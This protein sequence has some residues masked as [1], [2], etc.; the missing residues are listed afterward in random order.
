MNIKKTL[1]LVLIFSILMTSFVS[2][3]FAEEA[4]DIP[5]EDAAY[6]PAV[7][8]LSALGIME[9]K[10]DTE[11]GAE[12]LL[13][14]AEMSAVVTR[15]LGLEAG[16]TP[17]E[18]LVFDD[19]DASHWGKYYIDTAAALGIVNGSGDGI[20]DPDG[21]VTAEQAVK[22]LV[23][24]LGYEPKAVQSGGYP[25]GFVTTATQLG[26][27]KGIDFSDGMD[28]PI[29]RYK[30]AMLVYN[31]LEADL[32]EIK[33]YGDNQYSA[34]SKDT[35][36]LGAYHDTEKRTGTLTATYES[37]MVGKDLEPGEVIIDGEKY[38]TELNLGKYVGYEVDFYCREVKGRNKYEIIA[39]F[40][41][42]D[43]AALTIDFEDVETVT[44]SENLGVTVNYFKENGKS[45]KFNASKPVI[46]YNGKAVELADPA[47]AQ[48]FLDTHMVQGKLTYLDSSETGSGEII[49]LDNYDAYVVSRVDAE[50][51]KIF[52]NVYEVGR[53]NTLTL[54][55]ST[56]DN[57]DRKAFIY[58]ENGEEITLADLAANDVIMVYAS[59]D[60]ELYKVYQSKNQVTGVI[61]GISLKKSDS[62][63]ESEEGGE[64]EEQPYWETISTVTFDDFIMDANVK[65]GN[66]KRTVWSGKKTVTD[67][68]PGGKTRDRIIYL[69][70][71]TYYYYEQGR[72]PEV[73]VTHSP[74]AWGKWTGITYPPVVAN[75]EDTP[76][77]KGEKVFE[78]DRQY[79]FT[80]GNK[81]A[82]PDSTVTLYNIFNE[83]DV[84]LGD[85]V[86]ITAWVYAPSDKL[87]ETVGSPPRQNDDYTVSI[88]LSENEYTDRGLVNYV[89]ENG[90]R[91]HNQFEQATDDEVT[92][93][94]VPADQWNKVVMEYDINASNKNV[95]SIKI[96]NDNKTHTVGTYPYKF[97]VSGI[98]VEKYIDP[99]ADAGR[100]VLTADPTEY[101]IQI[102]GNEYTAASGFATSLLELGNSVTLLLDSNNKIV[103]YIRGLDKSGYGLLMDVG[104]KDETFGGGR[105]M[106]KILDADN[107]INIYETLAEVKAFNG[108]DV[109]KM[110]AADLVTNEPAD[111]LTDWH[112]WSTDN[113][114]NFEAVPRTWTP[115]SA[116]SKAASRKLVY[117]ETNSKGEVRTILVPSMPEDHPEARIIMVKDFE[118][119]PT[120]S[121]TST[122][123]HSYWPGFLTHQYTAGRAEPVYIM[124]NDAM[125]YWVWA[126]DY[127]E[128]DYHYHNGGLWEDNIINGMKW[129]QA[130]LYRLPGS[131]KIDFIV[132][133]PVRVDAYP[134]HAN[135]MIVDRISETEEG[136][137]FHGHATRNRGASNHDY[138]MKI[139][140]NLRLL[141]NLWMTA[142]D[143]GG[144]QL[145]WDNI[146][147]YTGTT[148]YSVS[149]EALGRKTPYVTPESVK[150]GDVVRVIALNNEIIY[151]EMIRRA[152]TGLVAPYS[153]VNKGNPEGVFS[154]DN[155]YTNGEIVE[156]NKAL[157]TVKIRGYYWGCS[158]ENVSVLDYSRADNS[159]KN[160]RITELTVDFAPYANVRI[161]DEAEPQQ[162][163]KQA[164]FFDFEIGDQILIV[165][166]M[167]QLQNSVILF[168]NDGE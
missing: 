153:V 115:E 68:T 59:L 70:E 149:Y 127:G 91:V 155:G 92:T 73:Y 14:R 168:K 35:N 76:E 5:A 132:M 113:A 32:M 129:E 11:F 19:V 101:E 143:S 139:S 6:Y 117:Y 16:I 136:Y 66:D 130:Q 38:T 154:K 41:V 2:A 134:E 57:S 50:G 159:N 156:I 64:D 89:N 108:T 112:L 80:G 165:G 31:A 33:S 74:W 15:F 164:S 85:K 119:V 110:P 161:W 107:K 54:D 8:V 151:L 78:L 131:K 51:M 167:E 163:Y 40:P 133:N 166:A 18:Q 46:M 81:M 100:P 24:A 97:Y 94:I 99:N 43:E 69:Q 9:G 158:N 150:P 27:L 103:G 144:V 82:S 60:K 145:T 147:D 67:T 28:K 86:R 3:A 106:L 1:S 162:K 160:N 30:I 98:K 124:T 128:E 148:P 53:I 72:N 140:E 49:F 29:P 63:S 79:H 142:P 126:D 13:T 123:F 125:K 39:L 116:K 21:N 105:L 36:A 84:A 52:C 48:E 47:E 137:I 157:G 22:I 75:E 20:F 90:G 83:S 120:N 138:T 88:W 109:V 55:L 87:L 146:S 122:L 102:G 71:G 7:T 25:G 95:S 104:L 37:A 17:N 10:S 65:N 4:V 111:P 118:Y 77:V 141:E 12:D 96:N 23:C 152:S 44:V 45:A 56:E 135:V 26:M 61:D 34:V 121:G 58:G 93:M 114:E 62:D 42:E